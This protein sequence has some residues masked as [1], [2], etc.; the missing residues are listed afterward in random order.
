MII[1]DRYAEARVKRE[2]DV[3]TTLLKAVIIIATVFLAAIALL[4]GSL[5]QGTV[6]MLCGFAIFAMYFFGW[7]YTSFEY[8]YLF[9]SGELD[10]DKILGAASRKRIISLNFNSLELIAPTNSDKVAPYKDEQRYVIYDCSS[11]DK[12]R[13]RYSVIC[14]NNDRLVHVVIEP[15]EEM[16]EL[17]KLTAPMKVFLE[18]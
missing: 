6:F 8:E 7:K 1:N 2:K 18:S 10:I 5:I 15:T 3:Q 4:F 16:L 11:G 14:T 17:F 13:N 9:L 12:T